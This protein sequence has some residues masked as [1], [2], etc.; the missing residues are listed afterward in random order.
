MPENPPIEPSIPS[1]PHVLEILGVVVL[2]VSVI[3][4]IRSVLNVYG[5][6][7]G[8]DFGEGYLAAMSQN[9]VLGNNPYHSL[10]R[11]PWIVSSYP[12]LYPFLNGLLMSVTGPSLIPGRFIATAAF[13]GI[14][15]TSIGILRKYSVGISIA[16]LSAGMMFVFPW[17]LRWAQVVRV[18]T[19]GIFFSI[20]G[21]FF[22]IRSEKSIDGIIA[23]L[24]LTAGVLTKH[25]LLAAP[26]ACL[27]YAFFSRDRRRAMLLILLVILIGGS[28]S[29]VNLLTGGGF[30]L[31]LFNYTANAWFIERF[32]AGVGEFFKATWILQVAALSAILTPGVPSGRKSILGWYYLLANG[33]LLA[34]GFEGSDTNYYIEPLLAASLLAGLTF[35]SM[36]NSESPA[37]IS[38]KGIPRSRTI[39][40]ALILTIMI[41]ARF[42]NPVAFQLHRVDNSE[43]LQNG[44]WLVRL[45]H[46]VPGNVLSEDASF[47]F[48][49]GKPVPFQPYIMSLLQR[50]GKWDQSDFVDSIRQGLY[51]VIIMRVDLTDPYNTESRGGAWEMAGFDRWTDEMEQA[52]LDSYSLHGAVDVGSPANLWFVYFPNLPDENPAPELPSPVDN[53]G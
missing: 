15:A 6:V 28:Y 9:L 37:N 27:L 52:I 40:F 31:H 3:L 53:T 16:L 1:R 44:Q 50:T 49:A 36:V 24:L 14:I 43:K 29:L 12:P 17:G 7:Y 51:S 25:S 4:F 13:I 23:A 5:I 2:F 35:N 30:F 10:D 32:S 39:A 18:D 20:L 38:L 21:I 8:I 33:T 47:P 19:L 48:L 26:L 34:Y 41:L 11:P 45:C 22:F 46:D 42:T